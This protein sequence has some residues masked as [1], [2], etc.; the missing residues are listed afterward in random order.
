MIISLSG[1][2]LA[3]MELFKDDLSF[4]SLLSLLS[5]LL[6]WLRSLTCVTLRR[7]VTLPPLGVNLML[8]DKKLSMN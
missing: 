3:E 5:L 7:T 2:E 8:F 1:A 4:L 6:L